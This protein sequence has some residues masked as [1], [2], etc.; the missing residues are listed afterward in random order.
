MR[1]AVGPAASSTLLRRSRA[2]PA[3]PSTASP[4]SLKRSVGVGLHQRRKDDGWVGEW[5]EW[6]VE[7]RRDKAGGTRN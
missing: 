1:A 7:T 5:N 2:E 3:P 4:S 6:W